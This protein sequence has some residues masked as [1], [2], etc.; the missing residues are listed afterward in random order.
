MGLFMTS[1]TCLHNNKKGNIFALL[2]AAVGLTGVLGVVGMQTVSG[3]IQTITKVTQKNITDTDVITNGRILILNATVR[4]ENDAADPN[5]DGDPEFEA[6]PMETTCSGT[7]VNGGCLTSDI[8]LVLTDPWGTNYGYCTWNHGATR[9][10]VADTLNGRTDT[11][12][13]VIAVI[14]A[15]PD[16][17]FNTTCNAYDDNATRASDP[18]G[19]SPDVVSGMRVDGTDDIAKVWSYAEAKANSGGLWSEVGATG[20]AIERDLAIGTGVNQISINQSTGQSDFPF[21]RLG[22]LS[23]RTGS[24]T[25]DMLGGL[26]LDTQT[27]VVNAECAGASDAGTLRWNSTGTSVEVCDGTAFVSV[28]TSG[29]EPWRVRDADGNTTIT[30]ATTAT[31]NEDTITM[32]TAGTTRMTISATGV[33]DIVGDTDIGGALTVDGNV[34]LGDAGTDT[35]TVTGD[36]TVSGD[37]ITMGTN[38]LGAVMVADGTN[39]NPVVMSG[40]AT[41]AAD[42]ALTI[43]ANAVEGSM[44]ADDTL[45]FDDFSDTMSLDASTSITADGTEVLSIVN[46]GTGNSFVVNDGVN[47]FIIDDSG[48]VSMAANAT[49]S[50]NLT[51]NGNVTLGDATADLVDIDGTLQI[52]AGDACSAGGDAGKLQYAGGTLQYCNGTAWQNASAPARLTDIG[53][54]ENG[55]EIVGN[56]EYV[57]VYDHDDLQWEA[58]N[59]SGLTAGSSINSDSA[60]QLIDGTPN[61]NNTWIRVTDDP[62]GFANNDIIRM[63]TSGNERLRIMP[64]G[65]V[66]IG[67]TTPL[68]ELSV[69]NATASSTIQIDGADTANSAVD[70]I[71]TGAG[72]VGGTGTARGWSTFAR[73]SSFAVANEQQD[74]AFSY[75]DGTSWNR[76]LTLNQTQYNVGINTS[77]PDNSSILDLTSTAKGLLPPRMTTVQRTAMT[78]TYTA[79]GI[80][81]GLVVYDTDLDALFVYDNDDTI[82]RSLGGAGGTAGSLVDSG[83]GDTSIE[84]DTA[85]DGSDNTTVFTNNTAETMRITSAGNVG[86]GTTTP[87]DKLHVA[88]NMRTDNSLILGLTPGSAPIYVTPTVDAGSISTNIIDWD[89]I[90]NT[91]ELDA[92][93]TIDMDTNTADLNFDGGTLFIDDDGQVGIGTA[94]PNASAILDITS[95]DKG[96]LLPRLTTIERDAMDDAYGAGEEGMTV[97]N[98]DD[99]TYQFW[100]GAAWQS[101][102]TSAGSSNEV[103]DGDTDTWIRVMDDDGTTDND[104]MRFAVGGS[105]ERMRISSAGNVG[106]GT[107]TPASALDVS[108]DISV[109]NYVKFGGVSG[110]APVYVTPTIPVANLTGNLDWNNLSNAMTLDA[111]TTIDMT[112]GDLN[113]DSGTLFIDNADFV[114]INN[115]SP[116]VALDVTGDIEYSGTLNGMSDRR[117]KTDIHELSP[118]DLIAKLSKIKT[119]EYK[120]KN[121]KNGR[122]EFGVMAQELEIL[123]PEL[124]RTA[125]DEMGTKSVNYIGL[126]IPMIEVSKALKVENDMLKAD[127]AALQSDTDVI[128]AQINMLNK[129][130]LGT[131]RGASFAPMMMML[132]GFIGGGLFM[133]ILVQRPSRKS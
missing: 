31:G 75:H 117:L 107:T 87:S 126:M 64:G 56:D 111:T 22:T 58:R 62:T 90:V 32:A 39:F 81:D 71:T 113:F 69:S 49:V 26:K 51:G 57:L 82:W 25:V 13:Y 66:G 76:V 131:V 73:G 98:E 33:L 14:S 93:T 18:G 129:A 108:G 114:G 40:D 3:P 48:N 85:G 128:K 72:V 130:T 119:Y 122:V 38:T 67:T 65:N 116:D 36:L 115:A 70:F 79:A 127:I 77:T 1:L 101:F 47:N 6:Y 46:T 84:V 120:M 102:A 80:A 30:M 104:T 112:A 94:T 16:K 95:T 7:P 54:V 118:D 20:A 17:T 109:S 15:G 106:I 124:V 121:D 8:G 91:M 10:G 99:N 9:T 100:D 45:D 125:K 24:N 44:V 42:G 43:S 123:F 41:I 78:T 50:G 60:K 133:W 97:Y 132:F 110:N 61:G 92:T 63:A 37:D 105:V 21:M 34:T 53:N 55:I 12:G 23:Q 19:L 74:F 86:I 4:P 28:A 2:F 68:E 52:G 88:G 5:Y 89:K 11:D 96:V 27:E 103:I 83:A 35:V 59:A 29:G